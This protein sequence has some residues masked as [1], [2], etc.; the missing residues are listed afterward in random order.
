M[1]K[2]AELIDRL[3]AVAKQEKPR[4]KTVLRE[5]QPYIVGVKEKDREKLIEDGAAEIIEEGVFEDQ[6]VWLV[7]KSRYHEDIGLAV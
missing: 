1:E 2:A 6:F 7:E 4:L 5:L 3:R